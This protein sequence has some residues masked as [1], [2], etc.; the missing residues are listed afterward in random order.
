MSLAKLSGRRLGDV[1]S[2]GVDGDNNTAR[3]VIEVPRLLDGTPIS[4]WTCTIH[5]MM[6]SEDMHE[7]ILELVQNEAACFYE[8]ELFNGIVDEGAYVYSLRFIH[9][10]GRVLNTENGQFTIVGRLDATGSVIEHT[11]PDI[12]TQLLNAQSALE[13]RIVN[14]ENGAT[15]E[16]T[17]A[18]VEAADASV[19]AEAKAYAETQPG[20][21][22]PQGPQGPAGPQG[23]KGDT[24]DAGPAGADGAQ[25]PQGE[26]GPMGPQGPKGDTGATGAVGPQGPK[27]DTGA[28]GPIGPMGPVGADGAD[29]ADGLTTAVQV[30]GITYQQSAGVVTLPDYPTVRPTWVGTQA[31]YDALGTYDS[32]TDY[33]IVG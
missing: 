10:D 8:L 29:G 28:Q 22:G 7:Q 15:G 32:S 14:L 4:E 2:I 25:G 33:Y 30:N 18:F 16:V 13:A 24:G 1:G 9:S 21:Q 23:P 19:L 3:L 27:G 26:I 20:P 5:L 12:I 17:Q 11:Q 31:E 6:P